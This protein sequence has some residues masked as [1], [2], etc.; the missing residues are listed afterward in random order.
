MSNAPLSRQERDA[1]IAQHAALFEEYEDVVDA[2]DVDT[3]RAGELRQEMSALETL[4]FD[5]LPR[6]Q[7]SRCPFCAEPFHH[8]F[9]PWGVNGFWWQEEAGEP[10]DEPP[11]CSHFGVLQ[12][13]LDLKGK[14][15]MGGVAF[16]AFVGPGVP[17][18]IPRVLTQDGVVA[19][20]SSL[21]MATGYRAY[22]I[23]YFARD[24]LPPGSFT[25]PWT[26]TSYSFAT[27]AGGFGW[28]V[29]TDPWDFDLTRWVDE[30]RVM[31]IEPGDEQMFVHARRDGRCPYVD[32]EGIREQQYIS[33][34]T[35]STRPPPAGEEVDP[36]S[37]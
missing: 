10:E 3:D 9:D 5:R 13:A 36:F 28:R 17:F 12:G 22:P 33:G 26:R 19:V 30:E 4:Y 1:L 11:T 23:V 16:E 29:D 18:V 31:W 37:E 27:A 8:S 21:P 25:N 24:P 14:P 35:L 6:P 15:P 20:I 7:L 32:L 2:D 34:D